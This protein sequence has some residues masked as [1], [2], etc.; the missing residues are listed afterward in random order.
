MLM[1]RSRWFG[2][3]PRDKDAT[4]LLAPSASRDLFGVPLLSGV[5]GSAAYILGTEHML[6]QQSW[7]R[8][9]LNSATSTLSFVAAHDDPIGMRIQTTAT[10]HHG[11]NMQYSRDGGTTTHPFFYASASRNLGCRFAFKTSDAS[12]TGIL[13]GFAPTST[14]LLN[15]S[16]VINVADFIG[17]YKA[18]GG[19]TAQVILRSSSTNNEIASFTVADNVWYR[20]GIRLEGRSQISVWINGVQTATTTMTNLPAN[21]TALAP[22][23]AF[24]GNNR[25]LTV[26]PEAVWQEQVDA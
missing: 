14:T 18:P 17:I 11:L 10:N 2:V 7:K 3:G 5:A 1:K 24:C 22:S 26:I 20:V 4:R 8:D 6:N 15:A 21:S 12:S 19:T 13:I 23:I 9:Q 16:S 25:T